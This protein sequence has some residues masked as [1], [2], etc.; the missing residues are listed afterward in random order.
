MKNILFVFLCLFCAFTATAQKT[1]LQDTSYTEVLQGK[2]YNVKLVT[3]TDGSYT[4]TATAQ[5]DTSAVF[6]EYVSKME[7]RGNQIADAMVVAMQARKAVI[8]FAYADTLCLQTTGRSPINLL[9]NAYTNDFETGSWEIVVTGTRTDVTFPVLST[10]QRKRLLPAGGTGKTMRVVG[11]LAW[12]TNYPFTGINILAK[13]NSGE[14]ANGDR[15]IVLKR[16]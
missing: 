12:I 9:M 7:A 1:Q 5:T 13:V 10:N 4:K 2:F 14:W 3:Y 8:E 11:R 15:T 6:N 16:K